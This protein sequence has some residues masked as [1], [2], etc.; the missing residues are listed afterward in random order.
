MNEG[1]ASDVLDPVVNAEVLTF[2]TPE[3]ARSVLDQIVRKG[4][5]TMLQA[6]LED[7]VNA[8]LELNST[9]VDGDGRRLVVR[10]GYMPSRELVTGAGNL[11]VSQPRV[12]DKSSDLENRVK[13]S[14]SILPPYLRRSKAIDELIPWLYLKG[15]STGDFSE[16]LQSL[17]GG[18]VDAVSAT[19]IVRLKETWAQDYEAWNKRDLSSKQYAY[20]WADGIHVNVRLEVEEKQRQCILV[21]MGATADGE[22]ELI[23]V[24]D[25]FRESEASWAELLNDLKDRG[26]KVDPQLAIGD[27]ALGFWAAVR[28]VFMKIREQRCWFHK[29]GNVLNHF[30]KSVQP[31]A[32]EALH[33]I[34][35]AETREEAH[36][37]FNRFGE[38]YGAKYPKAWE[39]L[40]KDKEELLAFYDFPAEHWKHLRTTNP[41]ESTFATIRLRHRKTKGSGNRKTSLVMMFKLAEA[42]SKRWRRLDGHEHII[43][44]LEGK[45]FVNGI[46]QD[47]A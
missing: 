18:P 29:S 17:T 33:E 28:K 3:S 13:F 39:C 10:N 16:A 4:A 40:E 11:E 2:G 47:A 7:E 24:R 31:R 42:A 14:S 38:M 19:T 27:G 8:F 20:I 21:L 23:A 32:K 15:I 1:K 43:S 6:A 46:L 45:K 37:A 25:G 26:L 44:L 9:K 41:I 12:R 35:M 22:K 36:K 30:P 34:W 5:R